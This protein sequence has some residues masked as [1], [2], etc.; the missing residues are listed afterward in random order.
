M[1]V[2]D[3]A[4]FLRFVSVWRELRV[5]V[6]GVFCPCGYSV[7]LV[8]FAEKTK[9]NLFWESVS[10]SL[11]VHPYINTMMFRLL[12][13]LVA[14]TVK[15]LPVT[16]QSQVW[17]LGWEEPLEWGH[18]NPLQYPCWRIPWTEEPG[19]LQSIRLLA[20]FVWILQ[21]CSPLSGFSLNITGS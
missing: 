10:C 8:S 7:I 3:Q 14:Q 13:F 20:A 1:L 5:E 18:G 19:G 6:W 16:Q 17:S 11:F 12:A 4:L 21:L 2:F 15:T 9:A